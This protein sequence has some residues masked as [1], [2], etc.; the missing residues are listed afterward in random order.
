M[1]HNEF[2][3]IGN[4]EQ[5]IYL[6]YANLKREVIVK[7]VPSTYKLICG[8]ANNSLSNISFKGEIVSGECSDQYYDC[9]KGNLIF[10]AISFRSM[11]MRWGLNRQQIEEFL[12]CNYEKRLRFKKINQKRYVLYELT[13]EN[14]VK[15][16]EEDN[17][18]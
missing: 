18:I 6:S 15:R 2:F 3:D 1:D 16:A 9:V 4:Y 10:P 5:D 8:K 11:L 14:I 13:T 7:L 12:C 17:I